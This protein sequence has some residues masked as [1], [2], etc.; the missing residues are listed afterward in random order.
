VTT[1]SPTNPTNPTN[2]PGSPAA[3]AALP[4]RRLAPA[5]L[6]ACLDL[7]ADRGWPREEHKWRLLLSAGQGFG[8]GAPAGDERGGGLIACVV[9]TSYGGTLTA[10]GMMLVAAR[11]ERRGLGLRLLRHALAESGT[12]AAVL[13]ATDAGRPLYE[14]LGFS[15][16]SSLATLRG[17]FTAPTTPR[18]AVRPA[19]AADV[20]AILAYDAP[21]FGADRTGLLTRLPSF[22]DQLLVA[23]AT[24]GGPGGPSDPGGP[25]T[26]YA[27]AWPNL[28]ST[29]I[30]PVLADDLPTAQALIARLAADAPAGVPLRFDA[31]AR[32]PELER[33]LRAG[34][35]DGRRDNT[36][37]L[38]GTATLPGDAGRR[39]APYSVALG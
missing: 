13:T 27:A 18:R 31:D 10:F 15:P 9:A 24:P 1:T 36:L 16:V 11:H 26:G 14:R 39:F 33:W 3:L 23:H 22:A 6:P 21:V 28:G 29:V 25:L 2:P 34:G 19:T 32:H 30:G 5:D 17:D 8:I 4:I 7:A 38:C 20:P 12:P 35:L 37:M